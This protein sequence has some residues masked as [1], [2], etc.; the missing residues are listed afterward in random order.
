MSTIIC[1]SVCIISNIFKNGGFMPKKKIHRTIRYDEDTFNF[2]TDVSKVS[3]VPRDKLVRLAVNAYKFV[4]ERKYPEVKN[5][6]R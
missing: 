2:Y 4:L 3:G 6:I 5:Y 1:V